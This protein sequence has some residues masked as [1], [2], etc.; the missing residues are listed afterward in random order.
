MGGVVDSNGTYS[1]LTTTAMVVDGVTVPVGSAVTSEYATTIYNQTTGQSGVAYQ[2]NF[3]TTGG[4]PL[5]NG[6]AFSIPVSAG[7]TLTYNTWSGAGQTS[8]S[9]FAPL[10][11]GPIP[12]GY[13]D[14][15]T[16]DDS[17]G[18]AF[19]DATGDKID[20]N[21]AILSGS[22]GNDDFVRAGDGNDTVSAGAGH[23]K[24]YGGNG[25]DSLDG[26]AGNDS[27]YGEAGNDTLMG[28]AGNDI[29]D[30]GDGTDLAS[31]ASSTAAVNVNLATAVS[32]GGYAADD[33][34]TGI[35]NLTGS[36]YNDTLTGDSNANAITG[37]AG[38]DSI[39]GGTGN[40][41]LFGGSGNDTVQGGLGQDLLDGGGQCGPSF[42]RRRQ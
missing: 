42:R 18:S 30:G 23:D 5:A 8:Y 14:G 34:L 7:D 13:V 37:G 31:Y 12:D 26:G 4:Y 16:G 24:I 27:L 25:N 33:T 20:N 1:Q 3:Y 32:S 39:D 19:T 40:D 28:G 6:V 11:S 2:I 22:S 35:E 21:D 29:L 10:S 9:T 36:S 38:A 17:I 41:Q 15:T